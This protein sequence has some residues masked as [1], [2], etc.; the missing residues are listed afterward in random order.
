M[1]VAAEL[2][3]VFIIRVEDGGPPVGRDSISSYF[4]RAISATD[5]KN[6]RCTGATLVT[7]PISGCAIFASAA[8]SPPCDMPISMTAASCSGSSF[9]SISGSPK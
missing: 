6:S 2:R 3:N 7:T 9:S 8:I 1:K 5:L 4:A